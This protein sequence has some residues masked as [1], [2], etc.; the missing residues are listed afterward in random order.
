MV[1]RNGFVPN[2]RAALFGNHR[3]E[4]I[5]LNLNGALIVVQDSEDEFRNSSVVSSQAQT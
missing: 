2:P 3:A 5:R 4:A 1:K